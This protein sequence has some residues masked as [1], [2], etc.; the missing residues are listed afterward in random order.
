MKSSHTAIL[1]ALPIFKVFVT[2]LSACSPAMRY[3]NWDVI[4]FPRDSHIPIQ[5]FKTSC[6]VTYN[7]GQYYNHL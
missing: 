2:T 3:E 6:F 7:E 5:E 1:V 4:L